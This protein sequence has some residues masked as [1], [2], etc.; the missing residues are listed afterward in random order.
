M[1]KLGRFRFSRGFLIVVGA[2]FAV[3]FLAYGWGTQ[4]WT[5]WKF[6]HE[7]KR[8]PVLNMTPEPLPTVGATRA[9]GVQLTDAGYMFEVPWTD[10][11]LKKTK[12]VGKNAVFIFRS[13]RVVTF[14]PP[15][16]PE[17]DL[18]AAAEKSFGDEHGN[19]RRL[20]GAEAVKSNYAFQKTLLEA[21]PAMITPWMSERECIRG[22]FILLLK[23]AASVGG[24]TGLFKVEGNGWKGFQFD[25][26]A[27]GPK[28]IT[29]ELYDE[30][31]RHAEVM[32][33]NSANLTETAITQADI[34]RV[35]LTL[36]AVD[37]PTSK[38][39]TS[40]ENAVAVN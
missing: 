7:A 14:F 20:L 16:P 3:L 36:R 5:T 29:L 24:D 22:G 39:A 11:D 35:L 19:L 4:A 23:T 37:Q 40:A 30:Q 12:Y 2:I 27:K 25:D 9:E 18:L 10:P 26:P 32:F 33:S 8:F 21:T 17:G 15:G 13:G 34:N 1:G 28:R 31:D 6:R 38:K